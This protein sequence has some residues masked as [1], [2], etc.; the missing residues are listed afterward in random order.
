MY[1]AAAD[2]DV[3]SEGSQEKHPNIPRMKKGRPYTVALDRTWEAVSDAL[4]TA[5]SRRTS[6]PR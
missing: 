4:S 2:G 3:G 6:S 5:V 1:A